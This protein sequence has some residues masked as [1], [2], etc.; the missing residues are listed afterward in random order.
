MGLSMPAIG[1]V[2]AACGSSGNNQTASGTNTTTGSGGVESTSTAG[3][4]A[5]SGGST[6]VVASPS[7]SGNLKTGGTPQNGGD[8]TVVFP[9]T[10]GDYDPQSAYDNQAS[11]VFFGAY[12]MLIQLKG[13]STSDYAPMLAKEWGPN[14][15]G[16][17]WTFTLNDNIKFHD[18][19]ACDA[20]AVVKSFQR[21]IKM[22]RGP[23]DVVARFVANPDTDITA[24]DAKTVKF[25]LKTPNPIFEAAIASEYGPFVV[26]PAAME[27][28]KTADD[29]YAHNWF[30]KNMAGTGPYKA[31]TINPQQVVLERFSDYYRG[32]SGSHFDRIIFRIVEDTAT[33]RTLIQGGSADALTNALTP[34]A[35]ADLKK[36]ANV[37]V[38][39]YPSTNVNWSWMN[40]GDRLKDPEVRQALSYAFPYD[41][42]RNGVYKG[43]LAKTGGPL[44]PTT[45]GYDKSVFIYETDLDKAKTLLNK[46]FKPGT[47]FSFMISS[48]SD[49]T[50]ALAQLFQ[51]NLQQIGYNLDIRQ[52]ERAARTNLAYGDAPPS[53][54]PDFFG[55]W[56]WWPDYNDGYNELF[57]N[58]YSKSAGSA[59]SN[60]GF[61]KNDRFDQILDTL[62]PGITDQA[63]YNQLLAEAQDILTKQDPPAIYW[64]MVTWYTVLRSNIRGFVW[65]PIY[66][67]WYNYY[68]MYRVS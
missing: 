55:D 10:V 7:A 62:A 60:V 5:A 15:D 27:Q 38:L 21:L 44:T 12:E 56:G 36:D 24:P 51:A 17:E 18:G 34:E 61:Y 28:H 41:D 57:P 20:N 42:V 1:W 23:Y 68:D 40:C 53:Q 13:H 65:N 35:V 4:S 32:W 54:R 47:K 46:H 43:L 16:S 9:S 2:L 39:E 8:Y 25:K 59:G 58:F 30:T 29:P 6:V 19:T 63:K 64:G 33:R 52:V 49:L 22:Q 48:G 11:C 26:S 66:L 37:Q 14:S 3:T 45:A 67:N 50:A 31:V